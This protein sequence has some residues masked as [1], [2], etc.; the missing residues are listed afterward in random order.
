MGSR[1]PPDQTGRIILPCEADDEPPPEGG[2][3]LAGWVCPGIPDGILAALGPRAVPRCGAAPL[4]PDQV[5]ALNR[6]LRDQLAG[7]R[8][9][10]EQLLDAIDLADPAME[11]HRR[12]L[13]RLL[14]DIERLLAPVGPGK[15]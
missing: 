2:C 11:G 12:S 8:A 13:A 15:A 6:S 5:A 10:A 7:L 3:S 9:S 14:R 4:P 1:V